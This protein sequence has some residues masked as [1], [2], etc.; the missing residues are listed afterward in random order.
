MANRRREHFRK[1]RKTHIRD[2][3]HSKTGWIGMLCAWAAAA[4]FVLSAVYSFLYDGDAGIQAGSAGL[5]GFVLAAGSLVL[6]ILAVREPKVRPVPPRVSLI[7]GAVMAAVF[8]GL[9]TYGLS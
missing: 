4:L 3:K 2:L 9:Y 6:G 7:L 5:V 1:T 8:G